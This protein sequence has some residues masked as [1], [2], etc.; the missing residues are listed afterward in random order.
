MK[1]LVAIANYGNGNRPHLERLLDTFR[2]M[3]WQVD[4]VVLSNIPK[5]LGPDVKV[6]VGLPTSDPWSLPF[7]HKQLFAEHADDY[8]LFIYTEDDT[9]ISQ[10]NIEAFLEATE[11]LA[12]DEIAGFMRYEQTDDGQRHFPE[13]HGHFRWDEHSAR[14]CGKFTIAHF[15][16]EHA[17]CFLLTR[18]Q[19]RKAIDSGGFLLQPRSGRYGVPETAA[20]DP[21]TQCGLKKMICISHIEDFLVPHLPNKYIGR[22]GLSE[23]DLKRQIDR[24]KQC[25]ASNG[26][27]N[28]H[29]WLR[30]ETCLP[31]SKWSK[32]YYEPVQQDIL[33]LLPDGCKRVLSVGCGWGATEQQLIERGVNVWGIPLDGVIAQCAAARGVKIVSG[34][35]SEAMIALQ[36]ERFDAVICSN[37]LHLLSDPVH[38]L[39]QLKGLLRERGVVIASVP[40]MNSLSVWWRRMRKA[41]G[42]SKVGAPDAGFSF[43]SER[44]MRSWLSAAGFQEKILQRRFSGRPAK[45]QQ[46]LKGLGDRW[47]ASEIVIAGERVS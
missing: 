22:L 42:Y 9:L 43:T 36:D 30:G 3:P 39:R 29:Y 37:L 13:V 11:C 41:P 17:A 32:E 27:L 46:M 2:A 19:L 33:D 28:G 38:E 8:D 18:G 15:T 45:V 16:N 1:V 44:V 35:L 6:R 24:L 21:Y 25:G 10:R 5:N 31:R 7:A 47:L 12:D 34:P 14:Q 23:Q 4:V 26:Q 40:N 20:T